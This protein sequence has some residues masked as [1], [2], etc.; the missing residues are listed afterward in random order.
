M[1]AA[2]VTNSSARHPLEHSTVHCVQS[3]TLGPIGPE[4]A[5]SRTVTD[6]SSHTTSWG[7]FLVLPSGLSTPPLCVHAGLG[8]G[9]TES[10]T[11]APSGDSRRELRELFHRLNQDVVDR[12]MM[13]T[14]LDDFLD[15]FEVLSHLP[16]SVSVF[17]GAR[18]RPGTL[19][20][21]LAEQVGLELGKLGFGVITGGGPGVMEAAAKGG[22]Q[23]GATCAGLTIKLPHEQ[24]TNPYLD[25]S[26]EFDYFF[27]R[28]VMFAKLSRGFI[29]CPGGF[30]T[31]DEIFEVLTLRQTG[32]MPEL[33]VVL[34][35]RDFWEPQMRFL[36]EQMLPRGYISQHDFD[37][38][39]VTDSPADAASFMMRHAP[40]RSKSS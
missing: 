8:H 29:G 3:G 28:K 31:L 22:K 6:C 34:L 33:P 20:Y 37:S 4:I 21:A 9:T 25:V 24:A 10:V 35:G 13:E 38:I 16:P 15:A 1:S 26:V 39:L 17:G 7:E 23:A 19:D 30:G 40:K 11:E 32:K 5:R 14:A 18:V 12:P 36:K 27:S 2:V